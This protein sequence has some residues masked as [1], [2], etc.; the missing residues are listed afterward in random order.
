ME[1]DWD[2]CVRDTTG[3]VIGPI[4]ELLPGGTKLTIEHPF[5]SIKAP[6]FRKVQVYVPGHVQAREFANKMIDTGSQ[7]LPE[8]IWE[9]GIGRRKQAYGWC[10]GIL[11][12]E[13]PASPL[14]SSS[15]SRHSNLRDGLCRRAEDYIRRNHL[16]PSDVLSYYE[17][18]T[19]RRGAGIYNLIGSSAGIEGWVASTISRRQNSNRPN[20]P[21]RSNS[22]DSSMDVTMVEPCG[23]QLGPPKA[24]PPL[25]WCAPVAQE[26]GS[27]ELFEEETLA[28][29]D[30]GAGVSWSAPE[31]LLEDFHHVTTLQLNHPHAEVQALDHRLDATELIMLHAEGGH[32]NP[33]GSMRQQEVALTPVQVVELEPSNTSPEHVMDEP[34]ATW[35]HEVILDYC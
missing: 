25:S 13:E 32:I 1:E 18:V 17:E 9:K 6:V 26:E 4:E 12:T 24:A 19:G 23:L 8:V 2:Y 7:H 29:G 34:L 16:R 11:E 33:D 21:N 3:A 10:G 22:S 31:D 14:D 15:S 35:L 20:R 30:T 28:C 5:G 27:L